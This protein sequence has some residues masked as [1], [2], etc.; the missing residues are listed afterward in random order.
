MTH[1]TDHDT[2]LTRLMAKFG[3][4]PS[5]ALLCRVAAFSGQH[6]ASPAQRALVRDQVARATDDVGPTIAREIRRWAVELRAAVLAAGVDDGR[7]CP[8]G[9]SDGSCWDGDTP[10][11]PLDV[12]R[13]GRRRRDDD[14]ER[15]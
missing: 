13:C 10:A 14:G 7:G 5:G 2:V 12:C 3:S 6:G 15:V 9:C 4:T 8:F 1:E 11:T